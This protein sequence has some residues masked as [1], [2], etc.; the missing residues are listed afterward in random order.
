MVPTYKPA[1]SFAFLKAWLQDEDYP[2]FDSD[3]S[4]PPAPTFV[5]T[6]YATMQA[7]SD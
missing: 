6:S 1:A 2:T 7:I 3:C 4:V 5:E